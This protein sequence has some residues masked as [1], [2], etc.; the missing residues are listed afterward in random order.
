MTSQHQGLLSSVRNF[1]DS[2]MIGSQVGMRLM[3]CDFPIV[4]TV[5]FSSKFSVFFNRWHS[6]WIQIWLCKHKWVI[7]HSFI[8][9]FIHSSIH[10][11]HPF[12][13]SR[14][15]FIPFNGWYSTFFLG[16]RTH[17]IPVTGLAKEEDTYYNI[18]IDLMAFINPEGQHAFPPVY[19]RVCT[20]SYSITHTH[21]CEF[22]IHI[23]KKKHKLHLYA[24][25]FHANYM[26]A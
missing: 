20:H 12:I 24:E 21:A 1:E 5:I 9:S 26:Y 25:T 16:E 2:K 23:S 19:S 4:F 3:T 8:Y 10:S 14:H 18:F 13:H 15:P 11:R 17:K 6:S 7:F 22:A